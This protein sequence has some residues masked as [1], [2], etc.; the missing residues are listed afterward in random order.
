MQTV[1]LFPTTQE[2]GGIDLSPAPPSAWLRPILMTACSADGTDIVQVDA[3]RWFERAARGNPQDIKKL[4]E[5]WFT[6]NTGEAGEEIVTSILRTLDTDTSLFLVRRELSSTSWTI[7]FDRRAV[8][9][10]I[11]ATQPDLRAFLDPLM[12]E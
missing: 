12:T 8:S 6:V 2:F 9:H 4:C 7:A 3:R 5:C 10:W 1:G 11:M